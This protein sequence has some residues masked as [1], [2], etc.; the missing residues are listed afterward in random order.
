M[1]VNASH[2][3]RYPSYINPLG[4]TDIVT[5]SIDKAKNS[6]CGKRCGYILPRVGIHNPVDEVFVA[7]S[8]I[9]PLDYALTLILVLDLFVSTVV[10]I[11][12]LGIRF[13]WYEI[14]MLPSE[15]Y[16]DNALH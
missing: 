14:F 15:G 7:A 9:F 10:G 8:K 2:C 3:V 16:T 4:G 1:G 11:S 13:L 5:F 12:F 6:T